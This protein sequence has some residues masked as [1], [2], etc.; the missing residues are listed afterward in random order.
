MTVGFGQREEKKIEE[1]EGEMGPVKEK[2]S[3]ELRLNYRN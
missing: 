2:A 3:G 1:R